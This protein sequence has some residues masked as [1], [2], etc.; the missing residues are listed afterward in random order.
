[1]L[2]FDHVWQAVLTIGALV[3]G[4]IHNNQRKELDDMKS[5]IVENHKTIEGHKLYAA[6]TYATSK[7]VESSIEKSEARLRE[8]IKQN[9]EHMLT[10]LDDIR[11]RL[12]RRN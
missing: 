11:D 5:Q 10:R 12:P 2:T 8:Q 4:W 3:L 6:E 9:H 1:M 7:E